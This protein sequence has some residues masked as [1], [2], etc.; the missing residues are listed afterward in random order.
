MLGGKLCNRSRRILNMRASLL[1][2]FFLSLFS[3]SSSSEAASLFETP[4]VQSL[5][6]Y[7]DCASRLAEQEGLKK[8]TPRDFADLLDKVCKQERDQAIALAVPI[9]EKN[10][11]LLADKLEKSQHLLTGKPEAIAR[12]SL[13]EIRKL[14]VVA[15]WESL[16]RAYPKDWGPISTW[17]TTTEFECAMEDDGPPQSK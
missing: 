3:A 7:I 2:V 13:V 10:Q 17:C 1:A 11:R 6:P 15:Y 16:R 9:L 4:Y 5:R 12:D 8:T 14:L